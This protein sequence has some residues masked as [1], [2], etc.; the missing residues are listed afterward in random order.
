MHLLMRRAPR[1]SGE[2]SAMIDARRER[3]GE[4]MFRWIME[5]LAGSVPVEFE[6]AFGLDESVKRL[7]AA[8]RRWMLSSMGQP[9]A[10][11]R[12]TAARVSLQRVIPMVGNSFKPFFVGRFEQRNGKVILAGRFTMS[13]FVKIFMTIWFAFCGFI[14]VAGVAAAIISPKAVPMPLMGG[15]MLLFGF[16]LVRLGRWFSRKDPAWLSDVIRTALHASEAAWPDGTVPAHSACQSA[17]QTP[18][19]I[20]IAATLLALFGVMGLVSAITG[21]QTYHSDLQRTVITHYANGTHR[22]VAAV[23]GVVM[24]GLAYGVYRR[25]LF[26]WKLCFGLLGG[27]WLYSLFDVSTRTDLGHARIPAIIFCTASIVIVLIWGWWWYAQRI[28]FHD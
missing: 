16:G 13:W 17:N 15:V 4:H 20:P 5:A 19:F 9:F 22:Y 12:V 6:S 27:S 14:A 26:A 11:G 23:Y 1:M 10:A 24:L 25:S 21:I 8:T 3:Q 2:Y 7:K 18:A 28:H